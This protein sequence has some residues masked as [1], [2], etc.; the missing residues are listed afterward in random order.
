MAF[1]RTALGW[2]S[3]YNPQGKAV[4]IAGLGDDQIRSYLGNQRNR[5]ALAAGWGRNDAG[6]VRRLTPAAPTSATPTPTTPQ[7]PS[8][9]P[10]N[11]HRSPWG[12]WRGPG[13]V[14]PQS[15]APAPDPAANPNTTGH[16]FNPWSSTLW[17]RRNVDGTIDLNAA[18]PGAND[19][20]LA[21]T[22]LMGQYLLP[23]A[24]AGN[25]P[26]G[27][28]FTDAPGVL[29]RSGAMWNLLQQLMPGESKLAY[30][31]AGGVGNRIEDVKRR[32]FLDEW[33]DQVNAAH[34]NL[35]ARGF[36]GKGGMRSNTDARAAVA[37]SQGLQGI[38]EQFGELARQ[39]I[40]SGQEDVRRNF[41]LNVLQMMN[42]DMLA[43]QQE[44][45]NDAVN[46]PDVSTAATDGPR[47]TPGKDLKIGG[48]TNIKGATFAG[49]VPLSNGQHAPLVKYANGKVAIHPQ[50]QRW[51]KSAGVKKKA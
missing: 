10:A 33:D 29:S 43:K 20:A 31:D 3:L 51:M 32:Q 16:F 41:G 21:N 12:P 25:A 36:T 5:G 7:S 23:G 39:Q 22:G 24:G 13:G 17:S 2:K 4:S 18:P 11:N 45:I 1:D 44:D 48:A 35:A 19:H 14:R 42:D 26:G 6:T 37:K 15:P 46:N 50:W 27:M 9:Q 38:D 30:L 28:K 40:R 34:G 47:W 8:T 49:R